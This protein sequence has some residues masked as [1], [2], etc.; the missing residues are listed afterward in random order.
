MFDCNMCCADFTPFSQAC[1][2]EVEL[3]IL[4]MEDFWHTGERYKS[5]TNSPENNLSVQQD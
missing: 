4:Q 1:V 2:E 5:L 3:M